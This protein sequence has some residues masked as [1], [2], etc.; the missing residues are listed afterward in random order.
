MN[1]RHCHQRPHAAAQGIQMSDGC[2]AALTT[3]ARANRLRCD[4]RACDDRHH[5]ALS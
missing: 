3:C 1:L 5:Q 2:H 4:G